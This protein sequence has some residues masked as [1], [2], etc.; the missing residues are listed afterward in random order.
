MLIFYLKI[1][2]V[3]CCSFP[4]KLYRLGGFVCVHIRQSHCV[5]LTFI[6]TCV[7]VSVIIVSC[8]FVNCVLNAFAICVGEMTVFSLK[9]IVL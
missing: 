1:D 4:R 9:V 7:V 2:V 3:Q 6:W 5:Y 8:R